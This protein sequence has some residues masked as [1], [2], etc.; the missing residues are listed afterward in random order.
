[1]LRPSIY[2]KSAPRALT[3]A[4]AALAGC[5]SSSPAG[6]GVASKTPTQ[7]LAA[8]KAAAD[9]AATVHVAGSLA[10]EGKPI[11]L[12]MELEAGKGGKGTISLEGLAV[13]IV[14]IKGTVY[15]N[16]SDAFYSHVA[17]SS[18]A[19]LL[20]G[21]WLKAPSSD[22]NFSSLA[23]L[24]ELG[25]LIGA[26]LAAHGALAGAGTTT[27]NGQ[28]AVGVTDKAKGGTLYVAT[29]GKAYPLE[30]A[31]SGKSGGKIVFDRWNQAVTLTAPAN[32]VN[33]DQLQSGH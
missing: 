19:Q 24:T 2:W 13:K 22:G 1:M 31:K 29:M 18:A 7:I 14:Q 32:A 28:K 12:N 26:T 25:K 8:A 21:K 4:V 10:Q 16:G 33:I 6:N 9:S 23:S 3:L 15:I 11:S 30:I 20:H 27:V 5:G 17:G